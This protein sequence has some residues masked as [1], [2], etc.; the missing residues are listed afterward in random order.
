MAKAKI[1]LIDDEADIQSTVKM[2]L[3]YEGY[4][5]IS[6]LTGEEG[7]QQIEDEHPDVILIDIKMPKMDGGEVFESLR[8]KGMLSPVI[9][10]SG[11]ATV[12]AAVDFIKRG[13][14]DFLE[15]PLEREKLLV[16]IRNAVEKKRLSEEFRDLK[17][18]FEEKFRIVGESDAIKKLR[19]AISKAAPSN[20]TVLIRGESGTGKELVARAIYKNSSRADKPFVK[21]N[22]AAIPEELIESELFGHE[23]GSFTGAVDKKI[24]KFEQADGGTIFLDEIGDMSHRTQAKVLRV[25]EQ[26]ELEKVGGSRLIVVNVRVIAATNKP[27]EEEIDA[28]RF[29]ADLF[30]RLNVIPIDVPPLRERK[31]DIP[32]LVKYFTENYCQENNFPMKIFTAAVLERFKD[33]QW[34]GNI[35]EL[36]NVVERLILMSP[37]NEI[38]AVDVDSI[39]PGSAEPT[40]Q[41]DLDVS[42][43][44]LETLKDFKETAEKLFLIQKLK[45]NNWNIAKTAKKIR[46]PRSNLYKKLEQYKIAIKKEGI[47]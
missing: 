20:S 34:K 22:C 39:L 29:R 5:T 2:I 44:Q 14:F 47:V 45:Q 19:D 12:S 28:G 13:A 3:D 10:I 38:T 41:K 32:L 18:Q 9:M 24:G 8:K 26:G 31:S 46:T 37:G 21:V 1:L 43:S 17:V 30:F 15:K 4:R 23:K 6:A 33:L 27:L 36:R 35:R 11:H 40:G 16:T 7:L 42:L 25:L